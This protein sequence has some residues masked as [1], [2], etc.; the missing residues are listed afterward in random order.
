MTKKELLEL[1]GSKISEGM[2]KKIAEKVACQN[3][4]AEASDQN[5]QRLMAA[6]FLQMFHKILTDGS[7]KLVE[8]YTDYSIEGFSKNFERP[9]VKETL[10][11]V[12]MEIA[13]E[14]DVIQYIDSPY[15]K[16]GLL[17]SHGVLNTLRK[18]QNKY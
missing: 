15:A 10:G 8:S 3:I 16:L 4:P 11:E 5:R 14:C 1:L 12:L 7:E 9:E 2:E 18:K 17:W 6:G 13:I